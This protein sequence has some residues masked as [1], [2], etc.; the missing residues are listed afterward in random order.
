MIGLSAS[1]SSPSSFREDPEVF[2]RFAAGAG[3]REIP[4][5]AILYAKAALP[6]G[7]QFN[8][9]LDPITPGR[10]ER[11]GRQEN[12]ME[13]HVLAAVPLVNLM[14]ESKCLLRH[15]ILT[16]PAAR[17]ISQKMFYPQRIEFR[18]RAALSFRT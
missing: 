10:Q 3:R 14:I 4:R 12:T 9:L 16:I 2:H 18:P 6:C 11:T 1:M 17:Q 5:R 13:G 7:R 15:G 8:V